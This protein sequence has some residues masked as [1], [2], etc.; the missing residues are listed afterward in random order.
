MTRSLKIAANEGD[1]NKLGPVAQAVGMGNALIISS[2]STRSAVTAS[3]ITLPD[4]AKALNLVRVFATAG[5]VT[6]VMTPVV[7]TPATTQV[8]IDVLGNIV[9]FATD[10]VTAAEVSYDV[11]EGDVITTN[12]TADATGLALVGGSGQARLLLSATAAGASRVVLARGATPAVTD[13]AI[14]LAGT[15]VKFNVA[16]AGKAC[17]ITFIE[18]PATPV[19][20]RLLGHVNF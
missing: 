19:L 7:G 10:A 17:V 5:A 12:V 15:G 6:G 2:M 11:M 20:A 3:K 14:V 16:D 4:N 18:F 1:T 8:S 9:F 13:A